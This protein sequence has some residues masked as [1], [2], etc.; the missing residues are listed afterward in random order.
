MEVKI[1]E[2][3]P[4]KKRVM[5]LLNHTTA[6][7]FEVP[8]LK[9]LG[10]NEIYLPK[11]IPDDP[12][13][14]SASVTYEEDDNLTIPK[15]LLEK[16]NSI[17]WYKDKVDSNIWKEINNYFDVIFFIV[18]D[19]YILEEFLLNFKGILIWRTYGLPAEDSYSKLITQMGNLKLVRLIETNK[20]FFF[21]QAYENLVD[22]EDDFLK[23]KAIFLPLGLPNK[24]EL[25]VFTGGS[26]KLLFVLPDIV[27]TPG[28]EEIYKDF[29]RAFKGIPKWIGGS[30]ILTHPG[31]DVLG[32]LSNDD[33]KRVMTT[34]EV[35]YYHSKYP[36]HLHFHPLEAVRRGMPLIFMAGG[37][38]DTLGGKGLPGR[39]KSYEEAKEKAELI[40]KG[41]TN[42]R[43]KVIKSQRILLE[44]LSLEYCTP[45]WRESFVFIEK[46][47]NASQEQRG[48]RNKIA[49]I[50]TNKT[51]TLLN[52]KALIKKLHDRDCEHDYELFFEKD[53]L[54]GGNSPNI[55]EIKSVCN[56][57]RK[58][59]Q[60]YFVGTNRFSENGK[61]LTNNS[62]DFIS[63]DNLIFFKPEPLVISS[64]YYYTVL[65]EDLSFAYLYKGNFIKNFTKLCCEFIRNAQRVIVPND[66]VAKALINICNLDVRRIEINEKLFT[67][68]YISNDDLPD[69]RMEKPVTVV[70]PD[71]IN[72]EESCKFLEDNKL[73]SN[74]TDVKIKYL[75][76]SNEP[77][78]LSTG[79]NGEKQC[80]LILPFIIPE[81]LS[82]I[83][84]FAKQ[85]FRI[86]SIGR[87]L[88]ADILNKHNNIADVIWLD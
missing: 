12:Y 71:G 25:Q 24:E 54:N 38:L 48:L 79:I 88:F 23:K 78:Y 72:K 81:H 15:E 40:L 39:A 36:R 57:L 30:Q 63:F 82:V 4:T 17:N 67:I 59:I 8:M 45:L 5:W 60:Y 2:S 43:N 1:M 56:D 68:N 69:P 26:G 44:K 42:F 50:I 76:F 52:Y 32:Y 61:I 87:R 18:L 53:A 7:E 9:A 46:I 64:L 22:I 75:D 10:Y 83:R 77:K 35:M 28:F 86:Y 6:R 62:D 11:V 37:M 31:K 80:F 13:F 27:T 65:V 84:Y 41:N 51:S 73:I 66:K 34:S 55:F 19:F 58:R 3:I 49:C 85:G 33:Y 74:Y 47:L 20:N 70:F 16:L 29:I 21:G 14:R